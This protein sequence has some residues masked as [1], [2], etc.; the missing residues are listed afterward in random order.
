MKKLFLAFMALFMAAFALDANAQILS[1]IEGMPPYKLGASVGMNIASFSGSPYQNTVGLQAGLNLMLDGSEYAANTFG[2]VELKYSMKGAY[3][4]SPQTKESYLQ[5]WY[6]V[7]YLEVPVHMGYAWYVN[8]DWSVMAEGGPYVA[9]GLWGNRKSTLH[10]GGREVHS[11]ETFFGDLNGTRFDFG[12]GLQLSAMYL[13]DYQIHVAYDFGFINL[14]PSF[15]QNR[16]LS[17]GF[18]YFFE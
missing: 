1:D 3:H 15:Q 6:K 11:N 10:T 16:N 2:R 9:L 18:T 8:E 17:V 13:Q 14:H 12:L 5:D 7:H 4:E